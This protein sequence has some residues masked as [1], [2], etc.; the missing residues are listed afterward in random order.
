MAYRNKKETIEIAGELGIDVSD[1]TWPEMQRAVAEA[2]KENDNLKPKSRRKT[3]SRINDRMKPY[4]GK[5]VLIS[6]EMGPDAKRYIHYQEELGDDIN[7]EEISML[8]F[9]GG[10]IDWSRNGDL[11][12][13]TYRTKGK[14]GRKVVAQSALP[15]Q[16]AQITIRP[17]IDYFPVVKF[18]N[19][20]GYLYKHHKMH[21][22]KDMLEELE[23]YD[24]YRNMIQRNGVL[25]YLT[26]LECIDI[27]TAHKIMRD[28]EDRFKRGDLGGWRA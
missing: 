10:K 8:G 9:E 13:K 19:K 22:F 12:T 3:N 23:V 6:P 21:C 26:G 18:M 5:T 24:D 11:V 20:Q 25:F 27:G 1:M 16:N 17:G 7:V 2:L 28:I 4:V 15:R 14:T